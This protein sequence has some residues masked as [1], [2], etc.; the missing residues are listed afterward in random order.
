MKWKTMTL[1]I[2]HIFNIFQSYKNR[3]QNSW[4]YYVSW[5]VLV[6]CSMLNILNMWNSEQV[7]PYLI[8]WNHIKIAQWKALFIK[9]F[10]STILHV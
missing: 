5:T 2:G 8:S 9:E 6:A 7:S 4:N 10:E 1:K 3:L